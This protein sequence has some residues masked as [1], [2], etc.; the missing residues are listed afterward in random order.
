MSEKR[1]GVRGGGGSIGESGVTRKNITRDSREI[2]GQAGPGK[3]W[4]RGK[5]GLCR[6]RKSYGCHQRG[7]LSSVELTEAF[8]VVEISMIV[9][10]SMMAYA[11]QAAIRSCLHSIQSYVQSYVRISVRMH[12]NVLIYRNV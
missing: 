1:I 11:C 7:G 6:S 5:R 2:F 9:E 10:S 12:M 4:K 8:V 3:G